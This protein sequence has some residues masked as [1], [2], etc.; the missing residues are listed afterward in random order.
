MPSLLLL[1]VSL[2]LIAYPILAT[3]L[4]RPQ[5]ATETRRKS[6]PKPD[7]ESDSTASGPRKTS[8]AWDTLSSASLPQLLHE[9]GPRSARSRPPSMRTI[10]SFSG[11]TEPMPTPTSLSTPLDTPVLGP[12][13]NHSP[14][15]YTHQTRNKRA[16][17]PLFILSIR[18]TTLILASLALFFAFAVL[19]AELFAWMMDIRMHRQV[20]ELRE[21]V[22]GRSEVK[23]CLCGR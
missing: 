21:L 15:N 17:F 5:A 22:L 19:V 7:S 12:V 23:L 20:R 6:H 8:A 3:Q 18:K 16:R 13:H 1:T 9:P 4:H 14:N 2:I 10:F 11:L